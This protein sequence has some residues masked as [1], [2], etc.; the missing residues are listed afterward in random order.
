MSDGHVCR[1]YDGVDIHI[2]LK[3]TDYDNKLGTVV[4]MP[5]DWD[6]NDPVC[7]AETGH[8]GHWWGVCSDRPGHKHGKLCRGK[9]FDGG[10]LLA[11]GAW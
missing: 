1:T 7:W 8:N 11:K 4:E 5:S 6:M 2:G 9:I 10:R 3:V